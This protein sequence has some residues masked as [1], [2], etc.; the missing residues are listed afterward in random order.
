MQI[1]MNLLL[2]TL[3]CMLWCLKVWPLAKRASLVLFPH[4]IKTTALRPLW[5]A[6]PM[7]SQVRGREV[8]CTWLLAPSIM[9]CQFLSIFKQ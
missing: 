6:S 7:S 1:H 5:E 3:V 9:W 4:F 8:E 2:C